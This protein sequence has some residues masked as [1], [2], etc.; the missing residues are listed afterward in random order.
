MTICGY[1]DISDLCCQKYLYQYADSISDGYIAIANSGLFAPVLRTDKDTGE[2][3]FL[4][5][6]STE[7]ISVCDTTDDSPIIGA[8][9]CYEIWRDQCNN[10]PSSPKLS[11]YKDTQKD[12][13]N[14]SYNN[15]LNSQFSTQ[16]DGNNIFL[17]RKPEDQ[18]VLTSR[19]LTTVLQYQSNPSDVSPTI[20]DSFGNIL[21]IPYTGL[22]QLYSEYNSSNNAITNLKNKMIMNIDN[23]ISAEE[24]SLSRW[25][26]SALS[27][28][29]GYPSGYPLNANEISS[30]DICSYDNYDVSC[31]NNLS[32]PS[33][34]IT[35][36]SGVIT[37]I[38]V[39]VFQG[40]LLPTLNA[41]PRIPSLSVKCCLPPPPDKCLD[42]GLDLTG[43]IVKVSYDRAACDEPHSCNLALFDLY[44]NDVLIGQ[45]N[46]NN[47]GGSTDPGGE[48]GGYRESLLTIRNKK[49]A[50]NK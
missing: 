42:Q 31:A 43:V 39:R 16:V 6:Y 48:L 12:I 1:E 29:S 38:P 13:I 37:V 50:L 5:P 2:I 47:A 10:T 21:S 23:A 20:T 32:F 17:D 14:T 49:N 4:N 11:S 46:L 26:L 24:V 15:V 7:T 45:A 30:Y 44:I 9:G 25:D 8:W 22:L 41:L 27:F 3:I 36:P 28:E 19:I 18:M 35:S 34:N 33:A 40:N